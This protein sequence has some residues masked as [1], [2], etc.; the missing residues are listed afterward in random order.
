M[1]LNRT[2]TRWAA[3]FLDA[4]DLSTNLQRMNRGLARIPNGAISLVSIAPALVV[5]LAFGSLAW[6]FDLYSSW[7][8]LGALRTMVMSALSGLV[9]AKLIGWVVQWVPFS[10]TLMP[11]ATEMFGSKFAQFGVPALQAAVW[12]FVMLDLATDIPHV[13]EFMGGFKTN[14]IPLEFAGAGFFEYLTNW[15]LLAGWMTYHVY[16]SSE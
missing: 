5:F 3:G 14:F 16:L 13:N 11:T 12:G 8:A 9:V 7:V 2:F 15:R 1:N 4:I 6:T 10:L